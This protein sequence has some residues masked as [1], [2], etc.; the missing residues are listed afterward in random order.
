MVNITRHPK[1]ATQE[2]E[3][4]FHN[5]DASRAADSDLVL[6]GCN[7]S[8]VMAGVQEDWGWLFEPPKLC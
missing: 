3:R 7:T 4:D 1:S 6:G 8:T 2:M 5:T